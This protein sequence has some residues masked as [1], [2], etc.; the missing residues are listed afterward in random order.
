MSLESRKELLLVPN[1]PSLTSHLTPGLG[2]TPM[3]K[4]WVT[5]GTRPNRWS[6]AWISGGPWCWEI[7]ALPGDAQATLRTQRR[8]PIPGGLT[9]GG[10]ELMSKKELN[11]EEMEESEGSGAGERGSK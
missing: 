7:T 8:P 2:Q 4:R 1:H 10:A 5:R 11:R 3:S 6:R 9:E